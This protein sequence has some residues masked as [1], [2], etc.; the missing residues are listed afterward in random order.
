MQVTKLNRVEA[1][2]LS[3]SVFTLSIITL[4][5]FGA[6]EPA[7]AGGTSA[8][9]CSNGCFDPEDCSRV[10]VGGG[11]YKRCCKNHKLFDCFSELVETKYCTNNFGDEA[12]PLPPSPFPVAGLRSCSEPYSCSEV[13]GNC[14]VVTC[15][16]D[17]DFGNC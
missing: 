4:V 3:A 11:T 14:F 16:F 9:G 12:P 10:R 6:G 7:R 17:R 1:A 5:G 15:D 13:I 2:L 8:Y